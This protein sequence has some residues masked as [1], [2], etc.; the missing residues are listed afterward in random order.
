MH[1]FLLAD[2]VLVE[3]VEVVNKFPRV[4]LGGGSGR[5]GTGS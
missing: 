3:L 2:R 4:V 5:E 1:L